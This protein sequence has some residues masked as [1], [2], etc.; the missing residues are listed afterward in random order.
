MKFKKKLLFL[1]TNTNNLKNIDVMKT[2]KLLFLILFVGTLSM[3][4]QGQTRTL[5]VFDSQ[6][7]DCLSYARAAGAQSTLPTIILEKEGI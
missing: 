7:S 2:I 5:T 4:A 6:K 1:Q 3:Q